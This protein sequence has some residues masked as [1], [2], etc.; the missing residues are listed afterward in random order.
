MA[1]A[2]AGWRERQHALR[3]PLNALGLYAAALQAR[4]LPPDQQPLMRG[5]IE[6]LAALEALVDQWAAEVARAES[7]VRVASCPGRE[8]APA[9]GVAGPADLPARTGPLA[10]SWAPQDEAPYSPGAGPT[11]F[12]IDD[13]PASRMSMSLLLEAWGAQVVEF[14]GLV[15]LDA[16]LEAPRGAPPRMVIVDYHLGAAGATGPQA[17]QR[18]RSAWPGRDIP[19][20]LITGDEAAALAVTGHDG[21]LA[22]LRKPVAPNTLLEAV[23]SQ[24]GGGPDSPLQG[25]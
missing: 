20:L 18:L 24:I 22:L 25:L 15:S 19:A 23:Q 10:P 3:Q 7:Q 6:S 5:I 14:D 17:L 1:E 9:A 8:D 2:L 12:V 13:D 11:V 21:R 16:A 4:P